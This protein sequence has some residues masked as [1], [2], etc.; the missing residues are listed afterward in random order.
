MPYNRR[1]VRTVCTPKLDAPL[2]HDSIPWQGPSQ[3]PMGLRN[4][5]SSHVIHP[6]GSQM[7]KQMGPPP[8]DSSFRPSS[9]DNTISP[10]ESMYRSDVERG[11]AE[12][13]PS[14]CLPACQMSCPLRALGWCIAA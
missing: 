5:Q 12:V 4:V 8:A 2:K 11:S 6:S 13:P 1:L 14:S 10:L 3:L 9:W 7:G